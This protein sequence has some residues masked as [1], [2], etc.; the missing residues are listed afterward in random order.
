MQTM[1]RLLVHHLHIA[2]A[3]LLLLAP[4]LAC[5]Q[6]LRPHVPI[7]TSRPVNFVT[8]SSGQRVHVERFGQHGSPVVLIHGFCSSTYSFRLLAPLL[9]RYHRV[10]ALDL[11]GFGY[12]QRPHNPDAYD[13]D[14]QA[15]L[16]RATLD[17]L[18]LDKVDLVGHS[19]GSVVAHRVAEMQPRRVGR[20]VLISPAT[21]VAPMPLAMRFP[22]AR[23]LMYPFLRL[24]LSSP[25]RYQSLLE[26]AFHKPDMPRLA[27]SEVYRNQLLVEGLSDAY[28]GFGRAMNAKMTSVLPAGDLLRQP[29]LIV[30]GQHDKLVPLATIRSSTTH[31]RK[32]KLVVFDDCGHSAPE[33]APDKTARVIERFLTP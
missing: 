29:I 20:L 25:R 3:F 6:P 19:F 15:E 9:A 2:R 14:G 21:S 32:A 12:T 7:V 18:D 33:E 22:P 30:A 1:P 11:N 10:F 16:V 23:Y 31:L 5:C 13:L 26:D 28:H 8:S 4:L 17:R 27:D 24:Y